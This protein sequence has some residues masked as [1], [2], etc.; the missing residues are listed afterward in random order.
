MMHNKS[1]SIMFIMTKVFPVNG[2]FRLKGNIEMLKDF[3]GK[4]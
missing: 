3:G 2:A 1:F 4:L